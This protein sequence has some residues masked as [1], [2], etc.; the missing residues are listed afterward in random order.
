MKK[1]EYK[2][3]ECNKC[4]K[5]F[6]SKHCNYITKDYIICFECEDDGIKCPECEEIKKIEKFL[7][8]LKCSNRYCSDTC[9]A[10]TSCQT[11][12]GICE[13]CFD[14]KC[15]ECHI[16]DIYCDEMYIDDSDIDLLPVC[17]ECKEKLFK[18]NNY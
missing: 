13:N 4:K 10:V 12:Y 9:I 18:E 15:T 14:Y 6:C 17:D 8:C 11:R 3:Y 1:K 2:K 7:K 5:I 16:N